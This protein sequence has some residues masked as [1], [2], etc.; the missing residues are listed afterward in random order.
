MAASEAIVL[1]GGLGTRLRQVV[2]DLPKPLAPV[3][4]RPFLAWLLDA[5]AANGMRRVILATGYRA[6][7]VQAAIGTRWQGMAVDYS[8]EEAPLGTGGAILKAATL[9]AGQGVHV[10]NGDTYLSYSPQALERVTHE[11]G[12][13]LGVGLAGVPDVGRYGAVE[14]L[15]G[16]L[17]G[18]REKG[19]SG[20]GL[21]NAGSYFLSAEALGMLPREAAWSFEERV[22]LPWCREGR[23]AAFDAT[24]DFIDIGVPEDF[25]RA[26]SQFAQGVA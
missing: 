15:D 8:R 5:L 11:N 14:V 19:G 21:I 23:V 4:G 2:P 25:A 24:R 20:P 17:A 26:Q 12:C 13:V 10:A 16:K 6:E 7:A 9:V 18:F 22:L 3:A 1:V